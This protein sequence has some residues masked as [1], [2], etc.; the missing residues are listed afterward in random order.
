MPKTRKVPPE[1]EA[2]DTQGLST[3]QLAEARALFTTLVNYAS[4]SGRRSIIN[5]FGKPVAALVPMQ[6][7]HRLIDADNAAR[8]SIISDTTGSSRLV[9]F[10]DV[11]E[12]AAEANA[13]NDEELALQRLGALVAEILSIDI[14]RGY[15]M[16][17]PERKKDEETSLSHSGTR[18]RNALEQVSRHR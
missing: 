11:E 3:Y 5:K 9:A 10:A 17:S 7:L 8:K 6:D 14:V 2:G 12:T 4:S 1:G 18:K 13:S 16:K 15:V